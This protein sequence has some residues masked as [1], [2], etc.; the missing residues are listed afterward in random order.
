MS[1][2]TPCCA[3][4]WRRAWVAGVDPSE[5]VVLR[6]V[7]PE[8][9]GPPLRLTYEVVAAC[10]IAETE[11]SGTLTCLLGSDPPPEPRVREVLHA[12]ARDEIHHGRLG[13]AYLAQPA[14]SEHPHAFLGPLIPGMLVHAEPFYR[15]SPGGD[16]E[17]EE[18]LRLGVLP[19]SQKRQVFSAM[20][21]QVIVPG[22]EKFGVDAAPTLA[23]LSRQEAQR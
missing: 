2:V 8:G 15:P 1:S 10:C 22:L 16:L 7:V 20:L 23:W 5:D 18:L 11:S 19:F 4:R 14:R 21:R 17:S 6:E 13:W 3:P 9:L 12:I